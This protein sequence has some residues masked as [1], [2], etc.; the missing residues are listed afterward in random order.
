MYVNLM[1][2]FSLMNFQR[3]LQNMLKLMIHLVKYITLTALL[4]A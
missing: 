2:L 4:P 3:K 1:L